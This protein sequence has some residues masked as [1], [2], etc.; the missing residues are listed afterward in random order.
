MPDIFTGVV[1]ISLY[2][3]MFCRTNLVLW[4]RIYLFLLTVI[5][6]TVHLTNI[7]LALG[8]I[9]ITWIFR[10]LTKNKNLLPEPDF[11]SASLAIFLA[12]ILIIATNYKNY[13]AFTFSRGGYSYLLARLVADGSAV[14]YLKESCPEKK[15]KLCDYLDQLPID[16]DKF[17]WQEESPFRKV[18]WIEKYRGEGTEI[19]KNTILQYPFL[20]IKNSLKNTIR[21]LPMINNWYG[22]ASYIHT[23]YPTNQIR[24]NYP[25]DFHAYAESRQNLYHLSLKLFNR[26]HRMVIYFSLLTA[27]VMFFIFLKFR[28]YLPLFLL[29]SIF[30]AYIISSFITGTFSEPHDRYG[31]RIIWLVPFFSIASLMHLSNNWKNYHWISIKSDSAEKEN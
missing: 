30:C 21:Q 29:I 8:I 9:V 13:G 15:Y 2:L 20:I 11:M 16:S 5:S 18:G 17:L 1:I 10:F 31:S 12:F 14:K 22:L 24:I 23:P 6:A 19:V 28:Q 4:E 3:L 7:P 26:L 27:A 25:G